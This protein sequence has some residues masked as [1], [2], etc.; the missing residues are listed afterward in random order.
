MYESGIVVNVAIPSSHDTLKFIKP[1]KKPLDF[2]SP[3]ESSQRPAV[4]RGSSLTIAL[5]QRNHLNSA[6]CQLLIERITRRRDISMLFW[7]SSTIGAP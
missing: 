1:G 2:P 3:A 5:M 6:L 4:L 7:S